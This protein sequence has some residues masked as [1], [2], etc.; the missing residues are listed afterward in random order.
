MYAVSVELLQPCYGARTMHNSGD[1]F[2]VNMIFQNLTWFD[3]IPIFCGRV[4][5]HV[6]IFG[7]SCCKHQSYGFSPGS[8]IKIRQPVSRRGR[9]ACAMAFIKATYIY[10]R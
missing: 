4:N 2:Y 5:S 1:I 7:P 10:N 3:F 9:H 8:A 6:F